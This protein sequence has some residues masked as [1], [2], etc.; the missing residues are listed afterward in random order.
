MWEVASLKTSI[1]S[2][3]GT[4]LGIALACAAVIV[5]L[6]ASAQTSSDEVRSDPLSQYRILKQEYSHELGPWEGKPDPNEKYEIADCAA[7]NGID[8]KIS[9]KD[10]TWEL[11][12]LAVDAA[13]I[14]GELPWLGF[15][16]S[17][18]EPAFREFEDTQLSNIIRK[19]GPFGEYDAEG[20]LDKL[21]SRLNEY[22]GSNH[23]IPEI[24]YDICGG[25]G[26]SVKF[27]IT[28]QNGQVF[29]VSELFYKFCKA[30]GKNPENREECDRWIEVPGGEEGP[31][32]GKY[33]YFASWPDGTVK[34]GIWDADEWADGKTVKVAK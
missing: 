13:F 6:P 4:N 31:L 22:R 34:R 28:P 20:A 10:P 32:S 23:D 21:V 7:V 9:E 15:P 26:I 29:R 27:I 1:L 8:F 25:H 30:Q 24:Y 33:R 18:W 2:L 19:S 16:P 3:A 17:V 12:K 14:E 5:S 11:L